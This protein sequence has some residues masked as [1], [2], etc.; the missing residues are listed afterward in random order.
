MSIFG[1]EARIE[2]LE[3]RVYELEADATYTWFGPRLPTMYSCPESA[4]LKDIV[5]GII[6]HL[7]I[8]LRYKPAMGA[9]VGLKSQV[10]FKEDSSEKDS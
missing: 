7:G 5:R 2:K 9:Q 1:L 10:A 6:T 4:P 8:T 3:K